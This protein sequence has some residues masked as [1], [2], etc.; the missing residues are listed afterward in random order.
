MREVLDTL[1]EG[2]AIEESDKANKALFAVFPLMLGVTLLLLMIQLQSFSRV[3]LVFLTFPLGLVGAVPAL[4]ARCQIWLC[5]W[6]VAAPRSAAALLILVRQHQ[7][8]RVGPW[9]AQ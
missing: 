6:P 5:Y 1:E 8:A 3:A 4:L 2:G 9:D 7:L